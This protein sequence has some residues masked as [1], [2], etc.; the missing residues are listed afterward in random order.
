MELRRI[1]I[2]LLI[3]FSSAFFGMQ[4]AFA[5]TSGNLGW[6][7]SSVQYVLEQKGDFAY[8]SAW[9]LYQVMKEKNMEVKHVATWGTSPYTDPDGKSYVTGIYLYSKDP[10]KLKKGAK[11]YVL[12]IRVYNDEEDGW[13]EDDFEL[14]RSLDKNRPWLEEFLSKTETAIIQ[15]IKIE[16]EMKDYD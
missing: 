13:F 11:Y 6:S 9:Y 2:T 15:D 16:E 8:R 4:H 14:W 1:I 7:S 12:T 10:L 3:T 5:Q